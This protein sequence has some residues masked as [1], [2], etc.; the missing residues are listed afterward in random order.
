MK[1]KIDANGN[2]ALVDGKPVYIHPD[3]TE[4]PFDAPSTVT[5]ISAM[6]AENKSHRERADA[7]EKALKLFDG[8]KDPA[9]AI[10]AMQTMQDLDHKKL[11]DIGEVAKVKDEVAKVYESKLSEATSA[12]DVLKN[13][14]FEQVV[15]GAFSRSKAISDKFVIPADLVQARF[16]Q[17]FG[18]EDDQIYAT[19][20][21]GNV[22]YSRE[23]PGS[24]ADFDEALMTLVEQYPYKD[25]IL[26]GTGANGGGSGSSGGGGSGGKR[27]VTRSQFDAMNPV[28]QAKAAKEA[29]LVD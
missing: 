14:L 11:V 28:E 26:K 15:G 12:L 18:I 7:A 23:K 5:T 19:D 9:A 22:I 21:A 16:G 2:A 29:T 24:K 27:V 1:L 3:G 25:A 13:K 17:H 20:A 6:K 10:K 4:V 8:I